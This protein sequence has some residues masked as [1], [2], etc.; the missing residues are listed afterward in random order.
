M[1]CRSDKGTVVIAAVESVAINL[2][3]ACVDESCSAFA[4]PLY[5]QLRDGYEHCSVLPMPDSVEQWRSEHRTARKRADRA[6]RLGYRFDTIRR[7]ERNEDIYAINTSLESRQGRRMSLA[8]QRHP[9]YAPLPDYPCDRH[10][11]S[12]YGVINARGTLV[13]YLW[14]YRVGS[15]ALVSSILGHGD[16]LAND[17]M[18]LLFQGAV[19]REAEHGGFFV[20]NRQ[21]S[22]T[23]GLRY[24]KA[25]LGFEGVDVEWSA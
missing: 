13:A 21:D 2:E 1:D 4:W 25:K 17:I 15:L 5:T 22:G 12:T 7:H 3:V 11:V 24:F 23:D 16:H 20:Y 8:Y 9:L 6:G 10:R 14:L 18:Y 19:E